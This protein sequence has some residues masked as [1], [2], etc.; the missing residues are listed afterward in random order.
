MSVGTGE[1]FDGHATHEEIFEDTVFDDFDALGGNAF[2]VVAV[3]AGEIDAGE[4][5]E[6][7]IVG[8]GEEVGENFFVDLFGEGLAFFAT[9]LALAFDAMAEDFVKKDGGGAAGEQGGAAV[10]LGEWGGAE[11]VEVVGDAGD[12]G[13]DFGLGRELGGIGVLKGFGALEHHAIVGEDLAFDKDAED[14]VGGD[15]VCA[16]GGDEITATGGGGEIDERFLNL[17]AAKGGGVAAGEIFPSLLVGEGGGSGLLD[18]RG[19]LFD[20][21]VG[22]LVFI[23]GA[24][25]SFGFDVGIGLA[26]LAVLL[27]GETPESAGDGV[28]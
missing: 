12:G 5:A 27:V 26:G 17:V 16:F 11:G 1:I 25:G 20:G 9:A 21:E 6:G 10:R 28:G 4:S 7:G 24:D 2:V 3:E 8:D 18:I 22:G 19:R 23:F 13:V 14:G 15:D